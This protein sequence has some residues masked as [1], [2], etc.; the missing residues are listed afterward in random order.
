M[1]DEHIGDIEKVGVFLGYSRDEYPLEEIR[2]LFAD[3][4]IEMC[5][6]EDDRQVPAGLSLIIAMGGDG[7]AL[8]TLAR[9]A[10][11]PVLAVNYGT[12]GF[13]T[14]G[15][16]KDLQGIIAR[17]KAG[18]FII[19][20]RLVLDCTYPQGE[21]CVFNE[22]VVRTRNRMVYTDVFVDG[23]K[24]RTIVG[25]GVVVGTPTG[26]TGLLLSGGAPIV[27]PDVRCMILDGI[28]EYNFTSRALILP[29]EA[30][31]RLR[32]TAETRERT[33]YLTVDGNLLGELTPGQEVNIR[34]SQR[35][36]RLLYFESDYFF[37]NL[38]SKLSW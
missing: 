37:R 17:L 9:F 28:Y 2:Q 32:I 25:D 15:D 4:G 18:D 38:S 14:A 10:D 27:M 16:R 24:I 3:H 36:A 1:A 33:I 22:A 12:V 13:L 8:K 35:R 6:L 29:P 30:Q 21:V 34:L 19:S 7:T 20:E 11:F 31:V 5:L 23:T 26:S